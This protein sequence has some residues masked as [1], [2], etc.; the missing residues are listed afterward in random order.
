MKK[1]GCMLIGLCGRSG[2]GKGYVSEI[3]AQYGIP[4]VD[5]DQVYR[6]MTAPSDTL[7]PCMR[8]LVERFGREAANDD[9]SL[10]RAVMRK[11]VFSGDKQALADLNR[12]THA[13]ILEETK[14]IAAELYKNG[15]DIV[16]IDAPLLFESGFDA[17]CEAVV[18]VTAPEQTLIRRIIRRDGLSEDDAKKRLAVQKTVAELEDRADFVISNDAEYEIML[19]R[20]KE[21][22]DALRKIRGERY[23][24]YEF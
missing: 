19:L 4:A 5:T 8:A 1:N 16:L 9:N 22:A 6:D 10:N 17:M 14:K 20:V 13:L 18:C 15:S 2:A 3:F 11:L 24:S 12:I 21:C 7:S 23:E